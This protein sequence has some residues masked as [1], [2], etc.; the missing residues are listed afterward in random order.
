MVNKEYEDYWGSESE[1]E[2]EA[3]SKSPNLKDAEEVAAE[4]EKEQAEESEETEEA[5][6][7]E[8]VEERK[9]APV[10]KPIVKKVAA[11]IAKAPAP[12]A[13]APVKKEPEVK[14]G[15]IP[16]QPEVVF[17]EVDGERILLDELPIRTFLEVRAI[18]KLLER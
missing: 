2:E 1:D 16:A 9:V 12:I 4:E 11:P 8:E 17:I 3:P 13:K 14:F 15:T 5:E 7:A 10:K 6:E 18:R